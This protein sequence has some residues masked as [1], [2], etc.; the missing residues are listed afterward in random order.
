[1]KQTSVKYDSKIGKHKFE[2]SYEPV[3]DKSANADE[4]NQ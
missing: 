2:W 4:A 3:V 1:M